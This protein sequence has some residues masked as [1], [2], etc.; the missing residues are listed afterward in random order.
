MQACSWGADKRQ[1]PRIKRTG[2]SSRSI[3]SPQSSA[4][5]R[6]EYT[7]SDPSPIVVST[8]Q[9]LHV[10]GT[11]EGLDAAELLRSFDPNPWP[12]RLASASRTSSGDGRAG[13]L[14]WGE[15]RRRQ[16]CGT[17]RLAARPG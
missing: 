14:V 9:L 7:T 11:S 15:I 3:S 13:F 16:G 4:R 1:R 2:K 17:G 6:P 5:K 12:G 8:E 10:H